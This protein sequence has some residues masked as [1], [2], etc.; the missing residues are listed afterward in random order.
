MYQFAHGLRAAVPTN[1]VLLAISSELNSVEFD[2]RPLNRNHSSHSAIPRFEA[3]E[4]EAVL[5]LLVS[6]APPN[7]PYPQFEQ[8][9][10][11][12][13]DARAPEYP[14]GQL[15]DIFARIR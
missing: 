15:I 7:T 9:I 13:I 12:R 14:P 1:S 8:L 11:L 5:D 6:L 4:A 2:V 3:F 10:H